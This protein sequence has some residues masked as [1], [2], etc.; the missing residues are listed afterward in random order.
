MPRTSVVATVAPDAVAPTL[1]AAAAAGKATFHVRRTD[2]SLRRMAY[3][4][5]GSQQRKLAEKIVAMRDKK[6]PVPM[7]DIAA[8]LHVSIPTVRRMINNLELTQHIEK[9]DAQIAVV[10]ANPEGIPEQR[11][12]SPSERR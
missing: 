8:N 1:Q 9:G 6:P 10:F 3:L 7:K 5:P 12:G 11:K 4:P 2:G